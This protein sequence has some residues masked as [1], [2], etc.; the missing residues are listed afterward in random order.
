MV[1]LPVIDTLLNRKGISVPKGLELGK[2]YG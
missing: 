2:L 1:N